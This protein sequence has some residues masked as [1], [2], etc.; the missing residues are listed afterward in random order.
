[1]GH[2]TER[3]N[4]LESSTTDEATSAAQPI[5]PD[6]AAT[7]ATPAQGAPSEP[8]SGT[9]AEAVRE[10][11]GLP[12]GP[13]PQADVE[14]AGAD[15]GSDQ[16]R[17]AASTE[18]S[19][20]APAPA[21]PER[22]AVAETSAAPAPAG[23]AASEVREAPATSQAPEVPAEPVTPVAAPAEARRPS[24]DDDDDAPYSPRVF[25]FDEPLAPAAHAGPEVAD[26][27][28]TAAKTSA[29]PSSS[30]PDAS[31]PEVYSPDASSPEAS[32][33]DA[34]STPTSSPQAASTQPL[35]TGSGVPQA[36]AA[37]ASPAAQAA[38]VPG[39]DV[40]DT[41]VTAPAAAAPAAVA[42]AAATPA[43][44]TPDTAATSAAASP[45]APATSPWTSAATSGAVASSAPAS[46]APARPSIASAFTPVGAPAPAPGQ[47]QA[48]DGPAGP[49]GPTDG[50]SPLDG[51]S[52]DK[53]PSRLP[54]VALWAGVGVLVLGG[55]YAG[56]QWF[57]SDKV[58][59]E[60]TVAG[61][62]VGGLDTQAA[63]E[64]LEKGL[65]GRA[66]EPITLQAGTSTT[67]LDPAAAG[68]VFDAQATAEELTSFSL[69]PARLWKHV[70]G[71]TDE[72]PVTTVDDKLLEAQVTELKARL[73][74][75]PVDGSV[76]FTDGQPVTTP[77]QDGSEI[78]EDEAFE[79]ISSSW[80]TT[81]GPL[82]LPTT[83]EAPAVT[84]QETDAALAQAQTVV[85]A[86]V[87][88]AV[89][90]QQA[91]LTPEVLA[92]AT[93]FNA[94]DG[95]LQPTF[96]G[97]T[98]LAA[99]VEGTDDLLDEA[100]D[101]KFVFVNGA[102]VIEGG[103]PGTTIDPAA[104]TTA[105]AE[106]AL[107]TERTATVE[108]VQSDPAQSVA[109]LEALGVK[110]KVS[111]FSTDLTSD[112]QRTENLRVGA[113][114]VNGTLVKP[115]ETF[116][117]TDTLSPITAA[118]GY[119]S[120]GIVQDGKHVEGI[121]GGL[122]QMATTTYNAGFYAG[123]E[124]VEHR[125]HSYWFSRYP[126]GREA[127]IFV[128]SIDMKFKNNTPYG[129]LL[130]SWVGGGQLH[131]AVWSTKY[132][133]VEE[134]SSGKQ[135]VVE[136]TTV[137]HSGPDCVA[138]PKGNAGFSITTYRKLLLEGKVVEEE[139]DRWTYKPDNQVVCGP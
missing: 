117:L 48:P 54:K 103:A 127:T 111:E 19:T 86:P 11:T 130:Q 80:L 49:S 137:T 128:G 58:P 71:G 68:L 41:Q 55:L 105:V 85:S 110:E 57:Y 67:T 96:D 77:A 108:L 76:V 34:S 123:L 17:P 61:I 52:G 99:V 32:S 94:V 22:A 72:E 81:S 135:N 13:R 132:W 62:E 15:T 18:A 21:A 30:S 43:A 73:A 66:E 112:A 37:E 50:G 53:A 133:T 138:Q 64:A 136:P 29:A 2:P 122:S 84:Q 106:A 4:A 79:I 42:P 92:S 59:P 23:P 87:T 113:S 46:A 115:G 16:A 78:V 1:M 26:A 95:V 131:V 24:F 3:E 45:F 10:Q 134:S 36:S 102:P 100:A 31:S 8:A 12:D 5:A 89:G 90:G 56:A 20:E 104:L 101:A 109:A 63:V 74:L 60:T 51:L 98:L 129:V 9:P 65:G 97:P 125:Q 120:A 27:S 33:P 7:P 35:V 126:A 69:S 28:E 114:K 40:R 121:G 116:S 83:P 119:Y 139:A 44:A 25:A 91:A 82:D 118:G 14:L 39:Q 75:E 6:P 93:S 38:T 70:L 88:V 107:G 47:A 124:D